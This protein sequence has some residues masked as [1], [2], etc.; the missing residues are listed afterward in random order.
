MSLFLSIVALAVGYGRQTERIRQN[1]R[2]L[3]DHKRENQQDIQASREAVRELREFL[4]VVKEF[5]REQAAVNQA[6]ARTLDSVTA[7]L[8]SIGD[9]VMQHKAIIELHTEV[10]GRRGIVASE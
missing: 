7:R 2:D 1:Q 9:L 6:V 8:E 3:D 5:S 4:A 10:L